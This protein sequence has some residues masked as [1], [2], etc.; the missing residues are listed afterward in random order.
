MAM[1]LYACPPD[2]SIDPS[3][4]QT[5]F[6]ANNPGF[7]SV[8]MRYAVSSGCTKL[9]RP[10]FL[11]SLWQLCALGLVQGGS[12]PDKNQDPGLASRITGDY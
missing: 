6:G 4:P 2:R 1:Y 8:S 5:P 12:F 9:A 10:C 11:V 3:Y 7:G